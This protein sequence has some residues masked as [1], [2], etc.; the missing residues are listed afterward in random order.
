MILRRKMRG[1]AKRLGQPV[2]S[3]SFNLGGM[4]AGLFLASYVDVFLVT[5]WALLLFPGVLSVRGAI[6]GIFCGHLSTALHLGTVRASYTKNTRRFH[7]IVTSVIVLTLCSSIVLGLTASLFGVI[8][9][10]ITFADSL[11]ILAVIIA[12]M[13]FSLVFISPITVGVSILFF[14]KGLD[15]DVIVYPVISTVADVIVTV[16]YIL[17]L[18]SFVSSHLGQLLIVFA[19]LVFLCIMCYVLVKNYQEALFVKTVKEFLLTLVLV[20]LIVNGTGSVFDKVSQ[21]VRG[22]P[23][24][25]TV[26]PALIDTVGD[27]GSIVGS[28]ATTK[29]ALGTI[30]RSFSSIKDHLVEVGGVWMAS[31]IMFSLY[32][33]TSSAI[34]SVTPLIEVMRFIIQLVITNVLAVSVIIVVSFAVAISSQKRG[35]DPDNFVIPIESAL[36][37]SITTIALFLTL[38]TIV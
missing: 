10:G 35:W 34:Y 24:I 15:P 20:A 3:L 5:P 9:L 19:D 1:L 36:A 6:G 37:D 38:I 26:Y 17:V 13:G 8:T 16:C 30:E 18:T 22:N 32:A 14:T 4:L 12:T 11:V 28:T 23:K 2:L 29:L 7:L 27:V 21:I 31:L 25:Y 33:I